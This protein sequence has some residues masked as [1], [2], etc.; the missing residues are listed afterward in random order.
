LPHDAGRRVL[1]VIPVH[2]HHEM[3]HEVL[4]DLARERELIDVVIVDNGGDYPTFDNE[5]VL[6]PGRN[7][8][9]AEG[10]NLGTRECARPQHDAFLWLNNDTRLSNGFV[11]G[12]VRSWQETG[13][14]IVGPLYDCYWVHQRA[15]RVVPVDQYR[16][17]AVYY[18]IPFV[19]GTAML[20]PTETVDAIGVLDAETFAPIGWGAEVDYSLRAKDAGLELVATGLS[21]LHHEKSATGRAIFEGGLLEYATRGY[22][23]AMEGLERKWGHAWRRTA[24][25]DPAT[26][27]TAR[28]ARVSRFSAS[29]YRSSRSR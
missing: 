5:Q 14:G 2:G 3:T 12:L 22:P 8:G 19:D 18:R 13:A 20:V 10:T 21:Y 29:R 17:R 7:L 6:R 25:I 11:T 23:V 16:P 4:A 26:H 9:W 28:P 15:R 24:G 27:Q 1:V